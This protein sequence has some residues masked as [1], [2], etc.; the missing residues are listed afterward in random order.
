MCDNLG[1]KALS[2]YVL[3]DDGPKSGD[4]ATGSLNIDQATLLV[5]SRSG[6]ADVACRMNLNVVSLWICHYTV[7]PT[8]MSLYNPRRLCSERRSRMYKVPKRLCAHVPSR[9]QDCTVE[10]WS[11]RRRW[12]LP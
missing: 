4:L 2:T 11:L 12:N 6:L 7:A 10:G 5:A 3:G 9:T 1:D 8:L